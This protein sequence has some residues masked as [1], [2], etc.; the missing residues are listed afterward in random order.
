MNNYWL[1]LLTISL[2]II[3]IALIDFR[4]WWKMKKN[5]V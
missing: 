4:R 3:P 1:M 5:N 2:V